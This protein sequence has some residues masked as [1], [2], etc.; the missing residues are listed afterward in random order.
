MRGTHSVGNNISREGGAILEV[1]M[2]DDD[3]DFSKECHVGGNIIES[4]ITE[5]LTSLPPVESRVTACHAMRGTRSA[6]NNIRE[7]GA[8]LYNDVNNFSKE[9]RI[10]GDIINSN[11]TE[12]LTSLPP[13][14]SRVTACHAMRATRS[15]GS[16]IREGDPILE[17][18]MDD[19]ENNLSSEC[20]MPGNSIES[21][22]TEG[23]SSLF[24]GGTG[25]CQTHCWRRV[26]LTAG[27]KDGIALGLIIGL[28]VRLVTGIAIRGLS[29]YIRVRLN[30]GLNK[31]GKLMVGLVV[32]LDVGTGIGLTVGFIVGL[33]AGAEDV[34]A[35]G[36]IIRLAVGLHVG[37][38]V[39]LSVGVIVGLTARTDN[40]IALKCIVRLAVG[41]DVGTGARL[42]VGVI[43]GLTAGAEDGISLRFIVGLAVGLDVGTDGL[44]D[45][46]RNGLAN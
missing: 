46:L 17:V 15:A 36:L 9:S 32:G 3:D 31:L 44:M 18:A 30:C 41:L 11:V 1:G 34:I 35:S 2:D 38:G 8:F 5:G 19:D 27:A 22:V 13:V 4:N 6:R 39:G 23:L 45:W 43:V 28:D 29:Q 33:T 10:G 40:R 37:P 12:G 42:T 25:W 16:N 21:D 14:E 24:D 20:H 7:G 26:G